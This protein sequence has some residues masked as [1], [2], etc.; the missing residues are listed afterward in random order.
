MRR[1]ALPWVVLCSVLSA[2]M[3][4]PATAA[5]SRWSPLEEL[6]RHDV[7]WTSP[8]LS[9]AGS[10]PLGNGALGANVW[11]EANGDLLLLL[12]HTDSFSECERLLKLGRVRIACQPPLDV[13]TFEQRLAVG[14]GA[15][16]IAAGRDATRAVVTV[17]V[18]VDAPTLHVVVDSDTPRKMQVVLEPWRTGARRIDGG[19]LVSSWLMRGA[20]PTVDI[21][22]SGDVVLD[23]ASEPEALVWYHR[24]EWSMVPFTLDHQGLRPIADAFS[25]PLIHRTFGCRVEGPGLR[26]DGALSLASSAPGGRATVR[27]TA[28]CAQTPSAEA[29]LAGLRANADAAVTESVARERTARWWG[30]RFGRSWVF[31]DVPAEAGGTP[32][33]VGPLAGVHPLRIGHDSNGANRFDGAVERVRVH[34]TALS[35]GDVAA[36]PNGAGRVA[37]GTTP[38]DVKAPP[39]PESLVGAVEALPAELRNASSVTIEAWIR[40]ARDGVTGRIADAIT[41]G[42]TDGL[43]FDLQGGRL[44]GIAGSATVQSDARPRAGEVSHVAMVCTGGPGLERVVALYLDGAL[45]GAS[46]A[47]RPSISVSQALAAQRFATLAATRGAFPVKFNGSIFTVE[48]KW[49]NGAPFDPDFRNWGGDYWWQNTRLPYHGMLARGD[50]DHL[51]SLFDFYLAAVPGC[52]ARAQLYH[53]VRGAYF[54]ETMTTFATYANGD[55]GWGRAGAAIADVHCPW[56]QWAWNQGPELVAMMLDHFDHTGDEALLRSHTIPMA[57]AVLEYFD[58]RFA[59]DAGGVL[60]ISPTQ[61]VETYWSDVVN[62]MPTVAGLR[63]VTARLCALPPDLGS[64]DDRALW[65]RLRSACPALPIEADAATGKPKLSPAERYAPKRSNC[66]SPELYAVWPFQ[67]SGVGRGLLE[68]GRRAFASR[69]DRFTNGWPQDGMD[70]ARLGLAD[71]AAANVLA[72]VA[73]THANFRFPTFWG[74]NFDWVPDQCHGGNLLTTVQEMLVQPVGEKILVLPAWPKAWSVRFRLHAPQR[75]VITG[76]VRDGA[77]VALEVEPTQRQAD[78]VLGDGWRMP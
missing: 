4:A 19:E 9:A 65:Q 51:R 10:M 71:E 11:V 64:S 23:A 70:A 53:N 17:F 77:L 58:S 78:V 16:E 63:E 50:G 38:V 66:E 20:P 46:G 59:R 56:W 26:R 69:H 41:A 6:A 21:R 42:G 34:R 32:N 12:S 18:D 67:H 29:W 45:V 68:E 7:V 75:T 39:A 31:V 36:L 40:P 35:A 1:V 22:E 14:R 15:L 24:N 3:A 49:V 25:D 55:Y 5:E 73:N 2:G 28:G 72:K 48:P 52:A 8:G 62:D 43:L 47:A 33:V 61:A 30:E 74:P 60:V 13:S 37:T 27:I 76:E 54:P 44:R 57:R